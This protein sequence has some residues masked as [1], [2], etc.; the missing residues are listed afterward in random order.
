MFI[1]TD[2]F[3]VEFSKHTPNLSEQFWWSQ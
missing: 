2:V 3:E 1:L